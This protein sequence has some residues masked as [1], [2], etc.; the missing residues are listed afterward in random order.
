MVNDRPRPTICLAMIVKNESAVIERCLNSVRNHVDSW[1][2]VDTGSE[3]DT[4]ERIQRTLAEVP[5]RLEQRPFNNFGYNR[6]E[7]MY[8]AFEQRAD[9]LLL[10]DADM[11]LEVDGDLHE[12]LSLVTRSEVLLVNEFGGDADVAMPHLVRGNRHWRF[13]GVT[14]EVL[15]TDGRPRPGRIPAVR[16]QDFADGYSRQEK[17][18][19]D[20]R[21]LESEH[22]RNPED[23]RTLFYLAQTYRDLG[24]ID[25][26][27]CCYAG[28][29]AMDSSEVWDE[30]TFYAEYQVGVLQ[31]ESNWPAAVDALLRAWSMRPTRAEPLYYLA[32][33]W[34]IREAWP[35][36]YLF[37][38]RGVHIPEPDDILFVDT[39]LYRW[40]LRFER[41]VA[42]WYVGERELARSYTEEL[43]SDPD[44]P[45]H[46]R[47]FA[48][49]NLRLSGG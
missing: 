40:G 19:R 25:S 24:Q 11:V 20:R 15:M 8:L 21:L 31:L 48:E 30:E 2:I 14:H 18:E 4:R 28:R 17:Y 3:D 43:L 46:W 38:S 41:S 16:I 36:A 47:V 5:G 29:A 34:R 10:L 33:G 23:P 35:A 37:A 44:L 39:P 9:W 13:E 27:V 12:L 32:F 45:D 6:T 22:E 1:V 49:E 26:A 42:A 7:L